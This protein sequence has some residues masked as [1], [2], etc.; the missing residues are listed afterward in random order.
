MTKLPKIILCGYHEA[1]KILSSP[2]K[3]DYVI[4][5]NDWGRAPLEALLKHP[6]PKRLVLTFDDIE[7]AEKRAHGFIGC[8][9]SDMQSVVRFTGTIAEDRSSEPTVLVQCAAGISRSAAVVLVLLSALLGRGQERTALD[10][11]EKVR[12]WS[13]D[14][15]YR[16]MDMPVRPNRRVVWL[17][18]E[19]LGTRGALLRALLTTYKYDRKFDPWG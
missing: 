16:P 15:G 13:E 17:G 6:A 5:I 10:Y 1:E 14:N 18:E 3:V 4:S 2:T 7:Q 12:K 9:L 19:A 11:L 8:T